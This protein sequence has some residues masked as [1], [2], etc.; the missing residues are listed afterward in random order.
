MDVF[1]VFK[2]EIP[3]DCAHS[4]SILNVSPFLSQVTSVFF[5][6]EINVFADDDQQNCW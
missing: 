2:P 5:C 3:T 6:Q 4:D 1:P